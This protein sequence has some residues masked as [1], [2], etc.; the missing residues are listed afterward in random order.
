MLDEDAFLNNWKKSIV[1]LILRKD[2]KAQLEI[3]G[4][5]SSSNIQKNFWKTLM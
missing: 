2:L 3:I 5:K 1:M 4:L